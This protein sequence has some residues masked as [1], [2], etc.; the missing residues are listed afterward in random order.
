MDRKTKLLPDLLDANFYGA[1]GL[2]PMSDSK[3]LS[4]ACGLAEF[5]DRLADKLDSKIG[6]DDKRKTENFEAIQKEKNQF[7]CGYADREAEHQ[8]LGGF[9]DSDEHVSRS[10]QAAHL[11]WADD[12]EVPDFEQ[13]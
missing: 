9:F 1:I 4:D 5:P 7:H 3:L 6:F 2:V 10:S 12:V 8:E 13:A 11:E